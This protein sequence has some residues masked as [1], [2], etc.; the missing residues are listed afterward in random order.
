MIFN[1][2][3]FRDSEKRRAA[4][5]PSN[6]V[7]RT[8]HA[9][10]STVMYH[11]VREVRSVRTIIGVMGGATADEAACAD[12]HSI[13]RLIAEHDL[14]LL[15]GGRNVGV[16]A[17]SAA[18]ASLAGGLV[19]GILPGDDLS[20]VAPGVDI[21]I[22]TGMGDA[23][24]A[25]NVLASRIVVALP[26][27]AGTI[28]EIALALKSDRPVVTIRMDLGAAFDPYRRTGRLIETSGAEEA[29]AA[30]LRILN[31]DRA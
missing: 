19:V 29:F 3:F 31:E 13:G 24:N 17:A 23:R 14:V 11:P 1:S 21:A 5:Q 18:G 15:S 30:V 22:P 4:Q 2:I 27:G 26:G 6:A 20:G 16:M 28:S 7:S 9:T 12:A 25:I 10:L 8:N